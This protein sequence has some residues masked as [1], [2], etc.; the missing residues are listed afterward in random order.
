M[1]FAREVHN[2]QTRRCSGNPYVDHLAEAAG[3]TASVLADGSELQEVMLATAWLHECVE[4]QG[5]TKYTLIDQFGE[6]VADGVMWLSDL[7]EGNR[8]NRKA[9][10]QRRLMRA[11]ER[12]QTIKWA[13]LISNT[14]SIVTQLLRTSRPQWRLFQPI[15]RQYG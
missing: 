5:V 1:E 12:V 15:H 7:E 9:L 2:D 3:I 4:D 14:S 11:P 8:T 13:D 10:S 6:H